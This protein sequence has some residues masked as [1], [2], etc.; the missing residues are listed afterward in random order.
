MRVLSLFQ[1]ESVMVTKELE[2]AVAE[3]DRGCL[4]VGVC[5]EPYSIGG[6]VRGMGVV[7]IRGTGEQVAWVLGTLNCF[8]LP[9][10]PQMIRV[11]SCE[12]I[13]TSCNDLCD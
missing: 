3:V 9:I 4:E 6:I 11:R 10:I 13:L 8:W 7:V 2:H 12:N 5:L 1:I